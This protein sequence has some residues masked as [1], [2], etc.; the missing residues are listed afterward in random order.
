MEPCF[1]PA[2]EK[3]AVG[4]VHRMGQKREVEIIRLLVK[5]SVES[6][7]ITF[8][9]RKYKTLKGNESDDNVGQK[10]GYYDL[11]TNVGN[12]NNDKTKIEIKTEELDILFGVTDGNS[13]DQEDTT[14]SMII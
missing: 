4:R 2:L 7:M 11:V 6:R 8:L 1:N 14:G 5:N 10:T 3:Q 13:C 12:L 9:D